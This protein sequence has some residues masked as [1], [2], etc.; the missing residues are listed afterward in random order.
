MRIMA[1]TP[2]VSYSINIIN[3]NCHFVKKKFPG[4]KKFTYF[5]ESRP[6]GHN[7]T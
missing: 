7:Q 3:V 1:L 6:N 4:D 5:F 2:T